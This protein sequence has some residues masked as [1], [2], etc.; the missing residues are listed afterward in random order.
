MKAKDLITFLQAAINTSPNGENA[1]IYVWPESDCNSD[2]E[3]QVPG[4]N[5]VQNCITG[6]GDIGLKIVKKV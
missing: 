1:E 6:K 5:Y 2:F 4:I 3:I